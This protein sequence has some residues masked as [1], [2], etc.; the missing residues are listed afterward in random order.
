VNKVQKVSK[1][2]DVLNP[3]IILENWGAGPFYFYDL[4]RDYSLSELEERL[5]IDWGSSTV[6]WCQK[7]LDK[8]VIEIL[9]KGF[10][11]TFL[12]Y[13][14]VILMFNELE[15]IVK[16]PDVNRQWKMMLSNVYGVYLILDT[17]NGQQ[18]VGS[19]YGKD[20]IW[21]RWSDYVHTKHGGNKILIELLTNDPMRYKKFQF[22]ILNVLPN[23][24]LR[25]QVIQLEQIT[26]TKLGTKTFGLNS[27]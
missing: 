1:L 2:P 5:V 4:I 6:S 10:A 9:P 18:Y 8:D 14:N 25:E 17:T 15:K 16:N 11:K 22:S 21:G 13:E 19:A 26:K 7:K 20:G 27:N 12:G 3:I 23:S 24:S